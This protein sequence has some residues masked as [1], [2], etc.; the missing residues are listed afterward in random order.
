MASVSTSHLIL[1]IASLIIAASVAG[2]FTQG[3]QR[4]SSA[5]GDRSIDLSGDIR[6]DISII[7]DPASGAVYNSAGEENITVLVKN[8][9][10]RPLEAESDQLEVIVDGKYQTSIAVTVLDGSAWRVGN[11]VRLEIDQS[12][13]GG[14]HRVKIIVNGDEEVLQFRT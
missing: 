11:V 13:S 4:L 5:L 9:G 3:V 7:S 6:T 2:T 14:D 10:S 1:F 12:L 8:T